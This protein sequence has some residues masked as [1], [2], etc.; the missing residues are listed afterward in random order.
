MSIKSNLTTLTIIVVVGA[1]SAI[2]VITI[3][4]VN[5]DKA[6]EPANPV[7]VGNPNDLSTGPPVPSCTAFFQG[8]HQGNPDDTREGCK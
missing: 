6:G 2:S 5:A 1:I 3:S 8:H 4:E 7:H